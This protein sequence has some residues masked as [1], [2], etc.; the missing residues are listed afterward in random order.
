MEGAVALHI[1]VCKVSQKIQ[2]KSDEYPAICALRGT[3]WNHHHVFDWHGQDAFQQGESNTSMPL[4]TVQAR[5]TTAV[6]M[7]P[8]HL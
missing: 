7:W 3:L 4:Y 6:C 1:S 2:R 5:L 8:E